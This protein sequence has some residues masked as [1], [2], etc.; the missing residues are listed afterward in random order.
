MMGFCHTVPVNDSAGM[1]RE[2]E[3]ASTRKTR[4]LAALSHDIR[5]P[6]NAIIA[7][8][9]IALA[10]GGGEDA[11]HTTSRASTTTAARRSPRRR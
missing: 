7:Q 1:R 4:F 11:D 6:A 5:T 8:M 10:E 3:E 9:N 2:A